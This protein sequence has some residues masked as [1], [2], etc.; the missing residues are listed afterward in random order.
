MVTLFK[1]FNFP[2][3]KLRKNMG[4]YNTH[5][6]TFFKKKLL[7]NICFKNIFNFPAKT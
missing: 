6:P 3:K 5:A 1:I 7:A 4:A 2:A